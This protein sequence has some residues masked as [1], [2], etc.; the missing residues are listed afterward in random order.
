[1]VLGKEVLGEPYAS[2]NERR[3]AVLRYVLDSVREDIKELGDDDDVPGQ[4]NKKL[5]V[6]GMLINQ[7][8]KLILVKLE[9]SPVLAAK[10]SNTEGLDFDHINFGVGKIWMVV[11]E[12][13]VA[14]NTRFGVFADAE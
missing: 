11:T 14:V 13:T 3:I 2:E 10:L 1:M 9:S 4:Y 5:D 7:T 12:D 6:C 8:L